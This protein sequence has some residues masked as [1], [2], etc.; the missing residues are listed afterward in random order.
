MRL[1]DVDI[2]RYIEETMAA[3]GADQ[4]KRNVMRDLDRR[5]DMYCIEEKPLAA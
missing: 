1:E 2:A 4:F 5:R 3:G